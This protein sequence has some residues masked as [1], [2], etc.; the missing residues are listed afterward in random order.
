LSELTIVS[1]SDSEATASA[2]Q[3]YA[4]AIICNKSK[5]VIDI[6]AKIIDLQYQ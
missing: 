1:H 4:H 6:K 2:I 3:Y 5:I